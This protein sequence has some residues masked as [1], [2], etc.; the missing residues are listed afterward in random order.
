MKMVVAILL[1][2]SAAM[3]QATKPAGGAGEKGSVEKPKLVTREEW[4]SEPQ[5][6]PD[7][8]K[9]TPK[10][11]TIHHAAVLW[12]ADR[13]A[14]TFVKGM[15]GWGQREKNWPD[16]PYHF[17]IA[18]DGRIFEGRPVEYEPDTNTNYKLQGHIGV[19]LMGNFNQQRAS[20]E[21]LQSV[22]KLV[23]WLCQDLKIDTSQV[24]TH[25]DVAPNQTECPGADFYRYVRDGVV[26]GWVKEKLQ[27]KEPE[28]KLLPPLPKG[29]T[30]MITE[31]PAATKPA[32]KPAE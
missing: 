5:P 23:A 26:Q 18:A 22:V 8:R 17:L 27:G 14:K 16:L 7:S 20:I 29:P 10:F 28:V 6:M 15:Q 30:T 31:T 11:I 1:M 3:A 2:C 21:Q 13:D 9:H 4:G 24:A 25:R 32:T 19:E 12:T